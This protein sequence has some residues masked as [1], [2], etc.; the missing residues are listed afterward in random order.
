MHA[1]S[2]EV[3]EQVEMAN[4][5]NGVETKGIIADTC[6]RLFIEKGY[7]DTTYSEIYKTAMV[8]PGTIAHHFGSKRNIAS[9]LYGE[10]MTTFVESAAR[11][12]SEED[13][14]QQAF[15]AYAMHRRLA[16]DD[17]QYNRFV[18]E[19]ML[20]D[21]ANDDEDRFID[22]S[23]GA[24]RATSEK[25][26]KAKAGFYFI[27]YKGIEAAVDSY[28]GRNP[29]SLTF[30]EMFA[31]FAEIYFAYLPREEV[32]ERTERTLKLL[33]GVNVKLENLQILVER[34]CP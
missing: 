29:G 9:M 26:G 7:R 27:A 13:D 12:F 19:F 21:I 10:F 34:S 20:D 6:R 30:D 23:F 1:A 11:L 33:K 31:Y 24:F 5:A 28:Y 22:E 25:I 3:R 18:M 17:E 32:A 15:I 14:I 8:N 4:Y 16:Y 2:D